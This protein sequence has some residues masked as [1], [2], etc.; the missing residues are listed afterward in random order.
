MKKIYLNLLLFFTIPALWTLEKNELSQQHQE[1]LNTY[2]ITDQQTQKKLDALFEKEE[3]VN[4]FIDPTIDYEDRV[5][6]LKNHQFSLIANKPH[7]CRHATVPEWVIKSV[8]LTSEN[9]SI[10]EQE[11]LESSCTLQRVLRAYCIQEVIKKYELE[12]LIIVPKKKWYHLPG[13]SWEIHDKNYLVLSEYIELQPTNIQMA[14]TSDQ[15]RAILIIMLAS[16]LLDIKP[17]N[18]WFRIDGRLAL[19][20]TELRSLKDRLSTPQECQNDLFDEELRVSLETFKRFCD[21][22]ILGLLSSQSPDTWYD[23]LEI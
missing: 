4:L 6:G 9:T 5:E 10:N 13:R 20:D 1:L 21:A 12:A 18:L 22:E 19:I 2:L 7:I 3:V 11:P 16:G 15:V 14:I 23:Y 17:E 8:P